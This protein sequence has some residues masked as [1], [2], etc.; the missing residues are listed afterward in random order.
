MNRSIRILRNGLGLLLLLALAAGAMWLIAQSR[1]RPLQVAQTSPLPTPTRSPVPSP[2]P[3]P[4]PTPRQP[5]PPPL[6]TQAAGRVLFCTFPGGGPPDKGGPGL[7][8][9]DFSEPRVILTSTVGIEIAD[10][11]PDNNRLL[12]S[13]ID[14]Q[15]GL[16][17]IETLDTR[18][19]EVQLYARP[20]S[21]NGRPIWL[22]AIQGVAY[23]DVL[24][25]ARGR[26]FALRISRGQPAETETIV[27]SEGNNVAMGFSLAVEPGGR[28]L[29][30]LVDHAIGRLQ[31][32][33]SV[34]RTNQ[35][36]AFDVGE[37]LP[38]LDL[39]Q[40]NAQYF[41]TP[42]WSPNGT[43]LAVF[44]G[45][46]LFLV[47][48]GPNRV[49]EVSRGRSWFVM[50]YTSQWSPNA[51]YLAIIAS[52]EQPDPLIKST[53]ILVLDVL[54]GELRQLP[55][56]TKRDLV[57]TIA[58]GA[59]SQHLAVLAKIT[60]GTPHANLFLVDVV[61]GDVRPMLSEHT[62]GSGAA[63]GQQM[64]WARNGRS[65]AL[66]CPAASDATGMIIQSGVCLVATET[67]P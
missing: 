36:T 40:P 45:Q 49:C 2:S 1:P 24:Y 46:S 61:T 47:E 6:P 20:D 48:P 41:V 51:R 23:S 31:S 43:L 35:A 55:L 9:Y 42:I 58:W 3:A 59:N 50:P 39:S 28:R 33:D 60:S 26:Q 56:S 32:W 25:T 44:A 30:Y 67:R 16:E 34:A 4:S 22:P 66:E 52:T 15:S 62:F 11:L 63:W 10:W 21:H 14:S 8:K 57:T 37:W 5:G 27:T 17:R 29:M 54:T 38:P 13:R 19:S 7:E 65:L 64:A 53:D 12:V 18:T